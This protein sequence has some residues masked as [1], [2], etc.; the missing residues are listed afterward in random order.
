LVETTDREGAS[1]AKIACGSALEIE[2]IDDRRSLHA[3]FQYQ[4]QAL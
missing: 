2:N 3:L 1:H 4:H